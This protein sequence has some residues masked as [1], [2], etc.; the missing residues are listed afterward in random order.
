MQFSYSGR[1]VLT[2]FQHLK[3]QVVLMVPLDHH[4][5]L[6]GIDLLAAQP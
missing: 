6:P 3:F 1:A 5:D 4:I 2:L